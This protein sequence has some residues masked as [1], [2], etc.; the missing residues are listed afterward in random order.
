T[1]EGYSTEFVL[2][3]NPHV[4]K[5]YNFFKGPSKSLRIKTCPLYD[6]GGEISNIFLIYEEVQEQNNS[7]TDATSK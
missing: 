6:E 2:N 7:G 3:Y 5:K 4:I 1:C